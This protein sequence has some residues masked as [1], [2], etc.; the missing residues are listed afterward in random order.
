MANSMH[1]WNGNHMVAI[2]IETGGL[3]PTWNEILSICMLP[4]DSNCDVRRD[5]LPFNI[6][7]K[8]T[9]P[10]RIEPAAIK[11]N[12]LKLEQIEKTGF[13]QIQA[14]ELF[15][16]WFEKLNIKYDKYGKRHKIIPLGHNYAGFDKPFITKWM[17]HETYNQYFHYHDRDTMH[18]AAYLNDRAG[19]HVEKI[20]FPK[21]SLRYV[22]SQLKIT[23]DNFHNALEDCK[24]TAA[25]YKKFI[26]MGLIG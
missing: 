1:C 26:T 19:M 14:L 25:V 16:K 9:H 10:T 6:L 7:M 3:D 20:P 5:V 21:L 15:E 18:T 17:G 2:D 4:L 13:D 11:I 12:K 24:V 23:S 22:A 8:P